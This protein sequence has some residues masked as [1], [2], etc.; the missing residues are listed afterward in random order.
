MKKFLAI[1]MTLALVLS[2]SAMA[3]AATEEDIAESRL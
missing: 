2:L 1:M 3:F